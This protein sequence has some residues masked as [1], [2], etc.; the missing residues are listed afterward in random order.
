MTHDPNPTPGGASRRP[1]TPQRRR[2]TYLPNRN[3]VWDVLDAT[4]TLREHAN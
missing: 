2:T 1:S 4:R 3:E